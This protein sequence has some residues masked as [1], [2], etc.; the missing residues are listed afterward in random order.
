MGEEE[1]EELKRLEAKSAKMAQTTTEHPGFE[2]EVEQK[3]HQMNQMDLMERSSVQQGTLSFNFIRR[4]LPS[5]RRISRSDALDKHV[6][7]IVCICFLFCSF[8]S[9]WIT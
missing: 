1:R 9:S 2:M 8:V 7:I 5:Y 6:E 4:N 3:E